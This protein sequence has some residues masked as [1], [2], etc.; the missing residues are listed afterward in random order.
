MR[1]IHK[2]GISSSIF[3]RVQ[4][5]EAFHASQPQHNW[6]KERCKYLDYI[7]IDLTHSA[8]P[9]Q[10]E[11][12]AALLHFRYHIKFLKKRFH[13]K[14]S[15]PSRNCPGCCQHEQRK[16]QIRIQRLFQEEKQCRD[17]LDSEKLDWQTCLSHSCRHVDLYS[18]QEHHRWPR[19]EQAVANR[20]ALT[21]TSGSW[22]ANWWNKSWGKDQDGH[23]TTKS[24]EFF[25]FRISDTRCD[26]NIVCNGKCTRIPCRTHI[27][28]H[29]L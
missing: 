23:V 8:F 28:L 29:M 26:N 11:R 20:E 6:T 19:K 17:D 27:F 4:N 22:K 14:S 1:K 9:E 10:V 16:E 2:K 18:I 25:S 15:R 5:D 12:H 13:E 21:Q 7:T 3:D 24:E